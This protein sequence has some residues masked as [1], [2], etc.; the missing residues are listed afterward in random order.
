MP[1]TNAERQQHGQSAQDSLESILQRAQNVGYIETIISNYRIGRE[2]FQNSRQFYVPFLIGFS[3]GTKWAL[4]TTTSMRTDRIKGQQ[5]DAINLKSINPSIT[6]AFLVYPDGLP[7]NDRNEFIRQNQKYISGYEYSAI[8]GVISQDQIS[9][10]I[11]E[12]ALSELNAGQQRDRQGNDY[13]NRVATTLSY[14]GNLEKW[15]TNSRTLEGMHYDMF[16]LIMNSFNVNPTEVTSISATADKRTIGRLPTGGNPKT[17]VLVTVQYND[18][19][20]RTF[21]ISCKR[22]SDRSVSVHQYSADSFADV[23]NP[24]DNNL[25]HLL[26]EFQQ[27][28]SLSAFGTENCILLEDALAPYQEEL[29][30]WVLGGFG[31]DGSEQQCANYILTY[32]NNNGN[33]S[34]HETH[35]YYCNLVAAGVTGH[36]GTIFSWTYPSGRRGLSI[37]LK[38][39]IL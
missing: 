23:L 34:I 27:N 28:P 35:D 13:E 39:R 36:F 31:G 26:N 10:M 4:F 12:V 5:W 19:T 16:L 9:N 38:C 37:Q 8:D 20:T 11:E 2:G 32:N 14:A 6:N 29:A 21:T 1:H 17:D 22:S 33:V 18:N 25:R 24:N 3:N 30:M 15:K 7:E